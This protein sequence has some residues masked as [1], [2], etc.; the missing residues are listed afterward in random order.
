MVVSIR[1]RSDLQMV[2]LNNGCPFRAS[3]SRRA[4]DLNDYKTITL[5]RTH[6]LIQPLL[7]QSVKYKML[8]RDPTP[9]LT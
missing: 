6:H 3:P 4:I 5:L 2:G 9:E 8:A 1:S 7:H